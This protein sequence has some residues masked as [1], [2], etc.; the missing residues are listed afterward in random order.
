VS[1]EHIRDYLESK[2]AKF[3][4]GA[5]WITALVLVLS[6]SMLF[7]LILG[8]EVGLLERVRMR[9]QHAPGEALQLLEQAIA[10]AGGSYPDA[11]VKKCEILGISQGWIEAERYYDTIESPEAS[12]QNV[13]IDLAAAA[14][15]SRAAWLAEKAL[16]AANHPGPEKERVLRM[17]L[18]VKY[19]LGEMGQAL[20]LCEELA[21][22]A[23][24]DPEPWL[25]S[26]GI[27]HGSEDFS[28]ALVAY[29]EALERSPPESQILRIRLHI[30]D[31]S[32]H[33]GDLKTAEQHIQILRNLDPTAPPV[34]V[35]F[36]KL[37][38]RKGRS[39]EAKAIAAEIVTRE[40]Q[41]PAALLLRGQLRY[42]DGDYRAAAADFL[43]VLGIN[44]FEYKAHYQLAQVY[45]RLEMTEESKHHFEESR[46]LTDAMSQ[47]LFLGQQL[48]QNPTD[49]ELRLRLAEQ[50]LILGDTQSAEHWRRTAEG[51][52]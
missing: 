24:K 50:H 3:R 35:V 27:H 25:I 10:D 16:T 17:L 43:A 44:P 34:G 33:L 52:R 48:D 51:I 39:A 4:V 20:I 19:D 47:V 38:R 5:F 37:L 13:L 29:Q 22:L 1:D 7:F 40:P 45:Q 49:R 9:Q 31:L 8:Q 6:G 26:A 21:K 12:D 14:Y 32:L 2:P 36:A 23:P 18:S 11:Q 41:F 28:P 30:A 42:E 15:Q 46:R